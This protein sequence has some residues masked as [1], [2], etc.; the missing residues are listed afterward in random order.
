M[1]KAFALFLLFLSGGVC[2]ALVL[3]FFIVF[4]EIGRGIASSGDTVA[5]SDIQVR[6]AIKESGINLPPVA[7]DLFYAIE[8][9]QDHGQYI[10]FTIP[11]DQ[12]WSVVEASLHKTREDFAPGRP[13]GFMYRVH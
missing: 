5:Y 8:G 4:R 12:L 10:A 13:E 9:F 2:G 3:H 6:R 11:R 7:W 1:K